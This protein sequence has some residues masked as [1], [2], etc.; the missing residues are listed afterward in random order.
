MQHTHA[1]SRAACS[2]SSV[3][4]KRNRN[5][6]IRES[7]GENSYTDHITMRQDFADPIDSSCRQDHLHFTNEE[8]GL[9]TMM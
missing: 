4:M 7:G 9:K 5:R 8:R 6:T 2:T 3:S 1:G